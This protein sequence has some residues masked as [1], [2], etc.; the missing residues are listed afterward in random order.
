MHEIWARSIFWAL[1]L[2][3]CNYVIPLTTDTS[4]K[5]LEAWDSLTEP[6]CWQDGRSRAVST[7]NGLLRLRFLAVGC[8]HTSPTL[9]DRLRHNSR[10]VSGKVV[11]EKRALKHPSRGGRTTPVSH[12]RQSVKASANAVEQQSQSAVILDREPSSLC[13]SSG[14]CGTTAVAITLSRRASKVLRFCCA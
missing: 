3:Q 8:Q 11:G 5:P 14:E 7:C 10:L 1:L 4:Y 6:D 2:R 13:A 9:C 12:V